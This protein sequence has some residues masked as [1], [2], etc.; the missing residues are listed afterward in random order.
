MSISVFE[1]R[2]FIANYR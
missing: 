2:N 1:A